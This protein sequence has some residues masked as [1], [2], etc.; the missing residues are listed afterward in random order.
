MLT[1]CM[2]QRWEELLLFN[3][4]PEYLKSSFGSNWGI[5]FEIMDF[6]R[7]STV[8]NESWRTKDPHST[9]AIFWL[10]VM[11]LFSADFPLLICD[12]GSRDIIAQTGTMTKNY[13]MSE[14]QL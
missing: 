10:G 11:S 7:M 9:G 14:L 4:D 6:V 12:I 13:S 8:N 2:N 5:F 3:E 1:V